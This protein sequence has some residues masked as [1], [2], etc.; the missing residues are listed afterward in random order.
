MHTE[1]T[2]IDGAHKV[3]LI[4]RSWTLLLRITGTDS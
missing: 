3:T 4:L 1:T 2:G